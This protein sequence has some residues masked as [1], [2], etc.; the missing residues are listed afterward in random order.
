[1]TVVFGRFRPGATG[2]WAIQLRRGD[3]PTA[4]AGRY[5][6]HE[7]NITDARQAALRLARRHGL[8]DF[9]LV[10]VSLPIRGWGGEDLPP[11]GDFREVTDLFIWSKILSAQQTGD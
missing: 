9:T 5:V 8:G 6:C 11:L 7:R 2:Y 10:R 1:M 3:I 4:V